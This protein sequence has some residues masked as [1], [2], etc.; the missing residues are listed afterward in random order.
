MCR[1]TLAD[2]ALQVG[3][4]ILDKA[5]PNRERGGAPDKVPGDTPLPTK[6]Y[7]TGKTSGAPAASST[8][9]NVYVNLLKIMVNLFILSG[10][11]PLPTA[12]QVALH[13]V[14]QPPQMH[15]LNCTVAWFTETCPPDCTRHAW[16]VSWQACFGTAGS[17]WS[18]YR[19][20]L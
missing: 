9:L 17:S 16:T 10:D 4:A 19:S 18:V 13:V 7:R 6:F 8:S 5:Q 12:L 11:T 20:I 3:E 14:P 15:W 2:L 1:H